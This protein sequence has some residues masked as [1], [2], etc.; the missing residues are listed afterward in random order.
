MRAGTQTLIQA[1]AAIPWTEDA[2]NDDD[3]LN[4]DP[5]VVSEPDSEDEDKF[6]TSSSVF[7]QLPC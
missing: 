1:L 3:V 5:D 7:F 6:G 2:E 4:H